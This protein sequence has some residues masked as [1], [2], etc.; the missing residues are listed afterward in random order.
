V[1]YLGPRQLGAGDEGEV[2]VR[3]KNIS[4]RVYGAD[5]ATQC[6]VLFTT[7]PRMP[8]NMVKIGS[9]RALGSRT[10]EP[11]SWE[12]NIENLKPDETREFKVRVKMNSLNDPAVKYFDRV[13]WH[14]DLK[15]RGQVIETANAQVR[16]S[17]KWEDFQ[18]EPSNAILFTGHHMS[19]AEWLLWKRILDGVVLNAALW[20]GKSQYSFDTC[21][22]D[23]LAVDYYNGISFDRTTR[24]KHRESW[25]HFPRDRAHQRMLII[26]PVSAEIFETLVFEDVLNHF[27]TF[28]FATESEVMSHDEDWGVVVIGPE[29]ELVRANVL[30]ICPEIPL[31]EKYEFAGFPIGKADEKDAMS[32]AKELLKKMQSKEP[33]FFMELGKVDVKLERGK[34][35]KW[36]Y[37]TM[38]V[39]RAPIRRTVKLIS[40]PG[41]QYA[42]PGHGMTGTDALALKNFARDTGMVQ[43]LLAITAALPLG[44]RLTLMEGP[45]GL[46]LQE[47]WSIDQG[48]VTFEDF[49]LLS[50]YRDLKS[51]YRHEERSFPH[52]KAL[53][54]HVAQHRDNYT[55]PTVKVV[56]AYCAAR[57]SS[58]ASLT[59]KMA[60]QFK[61]EIKSLVFSG[62]NKNED[63][64]AS[65]QAEALIKKH[66]KEDANVS[67]LLLPSVRWALERVNSDQE[68][69]QKKLDK[70]EKNKAKALEKEQKE[71]EK[72]LKKKK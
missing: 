12:L 51:D 43:I 45:H 23:I 42:R 28:P 9:S 65:E 26:P 2:S 67:T 1:S 7:D 61:K 58:Q 47:K 52:M 56:L 20:D 14:V 50:M 40:V 32:K 19:R 16:I 71:R 34:A 5:A 60:K 25:S 70:D 13:A 36:H 24:E 54:K 39:K 49:V 72:Q 27:K 6:S 8:P 63:K 11:N 10:L 21:H 62:S 55:S 31:P 3:V 46:T 48:P 17:P 41:Y 33:E 18:N 37:G 53:L 29:T 22:S 64:Q 66:K 44:Q 68:N 30:R 38:N 4:S 57:I 69:A 15:L 59:D 35:T